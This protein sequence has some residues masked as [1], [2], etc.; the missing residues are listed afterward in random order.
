[1]LVCGKTH[2]ALLLASKQKGLDWCYRARN[3]CYCCDVNAVSEG[4]IFPIS[5]ADFSIAECVSRAVSVLRCSLAV[6]CSVECIR[7]LGWDPP[8]IPAE[9]R[10]AGTCG[11][12]H[13]LE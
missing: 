9:L 7:C 8:R 1:M 11:A 6:E 12:T 3:Q 10:S 2:I 4:G 5:Q 13:G